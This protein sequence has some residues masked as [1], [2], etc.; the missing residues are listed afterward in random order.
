MEHRDPQEHE[1][2]ARAQ[3][4]HHDQARVQQQLPALHAAN[5][6]GRHLR[7]RLLRR[8]LLAADAGER[9]PATGPWRRGPGHRLRRRRSSQ[10]GRRQRACRAIRGREAV[11]RPLA[12]RRRALQALQHHLQEG[13]L[14]P[15]RLLRVLPLPAHG[16]EES[17]AL[18]GPAPR[19]QQAHASARCGRGA[20]AGGQLHAFH[21]GVP[22]GEV[23]IIT[24]AAAVNCSLCLI[25]EAAWWLDE[26]LARLGLPSDA[27]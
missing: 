19:E 11:L 2:Q 27:G 14:R 12:A 23:E 21:P 20:A 25:S 1:D 24:V 26:W 17:T 16:S 10:Q 5:M 7:P 13:G 8:R 15:R 6:G 18:Q 4:R 22:R 3:Q 9:A